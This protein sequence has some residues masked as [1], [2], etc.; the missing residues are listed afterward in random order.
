M[1]V[2]HVTHGGRPPRPGDTGPVLEA[3]PSD[4]VGEVGKAPLTKSKSGMSAELGHGVVIAYLA[5]QHRSPRR[6]ER[7]E[8]WAHRSS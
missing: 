3:R 7:K 8:S 1:C 6:N 4:R 5:V 2:F